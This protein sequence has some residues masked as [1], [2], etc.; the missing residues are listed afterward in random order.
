M[1]APSGRSQGR[2]HVRIRNQ[3]PGQ[4]TASRVGS[5][6][7]ETSQSFAT[8]A[9]HCSVDLPRNS[10]QRRSQGLVLLKTKNSACRVL[11]EF[12]FA[13]SIIFDLLQLGCMLHLAEHRSRLMCAVEIGGLGKV[14]YR[15]TLNCFICI[16]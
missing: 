3:R 1:S 4:S 12:A 9:E 6:S 8:P 2:P 13:Y 15:F 14:C 7:N 16:L 10:R 11:Y 5:L